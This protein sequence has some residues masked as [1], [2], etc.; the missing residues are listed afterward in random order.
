V[1]IGDKQ[2]LGHKDRRAIQPSFY[3]RVTR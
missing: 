1:Q 3:T 2:G